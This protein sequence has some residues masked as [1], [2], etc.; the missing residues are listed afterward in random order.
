MREKFLNKDVTPPDTGMDG[1]EKRSPR[2]RFLKPILLGVI[3]AYILVAAF[4]V[5]ILTAIGKFLVIEHDISKSDLLVC[6]AG[7]NIERGLATA[8]IYHKGLAPRIFIAPEE[9]P[10]GLDLLEGK[11]IHYPRTIE[12][13]VRLFQELG[14]PGSAIL[15][16]EHPSGSTKG[17][18]DMVRD[19]VEKEK[20][21]SIIL[22][23]SPT[24]TRRTYLTFSRVM[25]EK[26]VRIQIFPTRYSNFSA[27]EWWK[28]RKYVREVILEYEKLVYYYLKELR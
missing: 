15:I 17:E 24:H 20:Y 19:L 14:V 11:G 27:E 13:M 4:H 3:L 5:Q 22:I 2:G 23:T 26:D 6:L 10:D 9:P 25:E 16:G 8:D 21:R 12:L 18:A 28:H 1:P 7:A